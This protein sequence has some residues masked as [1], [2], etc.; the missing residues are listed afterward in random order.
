M[1]E[2]SCHASQAILHGLLRN[3][4]AGFR[5][6]SYMKTNLSSKGKILLP[7]EFLEQDNLRPGQLFS[8]ERVE[9][10]QYLLTA[11][12]NTDNGSLA[13]WLSTCPEK[14]W[15]QPLKSESTSNLTVE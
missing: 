14:G 13:E 5:H 15:F 9:A 7:A 12:S 8:I 11:I 3:Y 6:R 2:L 10:G 4:E 1:P